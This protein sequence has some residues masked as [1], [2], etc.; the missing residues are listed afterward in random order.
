M[1]KIANVALLCVFATQMVYAQKRAPENWFNLDMKKD[2]VPGVST[3]RAYNELL[4]GKKSEPIVVAVIDGGTE[5]LHEDLKDIIWV[6]PNE[7]PDNGIDDDNN[8]Y[9]DDTNGWSFLGGKVGDV[10]EETLE[11]TRMARDM[12]RLFGDKKR[13]EMSEDEQK[14]FDIYSA[15][16]KEFSI[17]A[18]EASNNLNF[19]NTFSKTIERMQKYAGTE[20]P[21]P[22]EV[23]NFYSTD[24]M[25]AAIAKRIQDIIKKGAKLDDL[26]KQLV[27]AKDH[28]ES[29]LKYHLNKDFDPRHLV[30]DNIDDPTE[31]FYGCNRVSGPKGEHGTHVAGII[32][33]IRNNGIGMN[34]V[35]NNARIM[36]LRTVPDGDER[37]KDIANSIRYAVDNGAKIIN[38]SFGK[39]YSPDK[40]VV[41]DAV[42]YANLNGV[43]I[44]HAA[45]NDAKN[46]D[47]ENNF[48]RADYLDGTTASNWI[49]V[50]ASS[51]KKGKD[52]PAT[53]SNYSKRNVDVF[54]PG[55]DIYS[56]I[57]ESQYASFNGTSMASPVTA[58]VAALIWSYYPNLTASQVKDII[59]KSAVPVK[60]K[61][62]PPGGTKKNMTSMTELCKTGAI[63]N[64]YQ[65]ILLAEKMSK[66]N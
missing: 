37:D 66:N 25:E 59:L 10:V 29:Q 21:K 31:Q 65:A 63:V 18:T 5:V 44:V 40:K 56:C 42:K 2:K 58:G 17:K 20:N 62:I 11:I 45:G 36:I 14:Q 34:G 26:K 7:I 30:G 33:A 57:P 50:G 48:P 9:V 15:A 53:F 41:D 32:A 23:K 46:T 47:E 52:I 8:G 3:E 54:A 55:V 27:G 39:N 22:D 51:W 6:N 28:F 43:L 60:G 16:V 61:V 1:N 4:K 49:E 13:D 35:S 12:K 38:M 19:Y 24:P 64:A